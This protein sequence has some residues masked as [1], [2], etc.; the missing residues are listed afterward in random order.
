MSKKHEMQRLIR[1]Y[2]DE[3]GNR[4]VDMKEVA[5]WSVGKGWPLPTPRNPIDILAQNFAEAAREETRRDTKTGRP[6]RANHSFSV[7]Q[8]GQQL[9]LWIDIDEAD[10]GPM[11]KSAVTRREQMVGDGLHLTLDLMHW[12]SINPEKKPIELP[13]D[14]TFDIELRLNAPDEDGKRA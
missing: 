4:V 13:M 10:R 3:T 9:H 14:L 11:L 8:G 5:K 12:N 1:T 6:Y 7:A 2:K